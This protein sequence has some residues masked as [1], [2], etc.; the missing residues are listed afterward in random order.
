MY[1]NGRRKKNKQTNTSIEELCLSLRTDLVY[2]LWFTAAVITVSLKTV[3][4]GKV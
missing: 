1:L 4:P 2:R 3:L